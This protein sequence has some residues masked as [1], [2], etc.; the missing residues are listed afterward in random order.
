M[1]KTYPE[2]KNNKRMDVSKI[3][4]LNIIK[5]EEGNIL[6]GSIL[7][8]VSPIKCDFVYSKYSTS[9]IS[10]EKGMSKQER[11]ACESE[12]TSEDIK[13][14]LTDVLHSDMNKD[15]VIWSFDDTDIIYTNS[16]K[17]FYDLKDFEELVEYLEYEKNKEIQYSADMNDSLFKNMFC[18]AFMFKKNYFV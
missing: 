11:F 5:D 16:I 6:Q 8:M 14:E 7:N 17:H 3:L 12:L 13:K 9:G 10:K 1:A 18:L 2:S 4:F 15:Q